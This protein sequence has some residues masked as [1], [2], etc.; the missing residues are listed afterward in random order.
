MPL[1]VNKPSNSGKKLPISPNIKIPSTDLAFLSQILKQFLAA[2][3]KPTLNGMTKTPIDG[4]RVFRDPHGS[5]KQ[6]LLYQSGI[7]IMLQGTKRL[8]V[9]NREIE[10]K[11]GDYI[12]FGVPLPAQCAATLE[13]DDCI[14]GLVIDIPAALLVELSQWRD[15]SAKNSPAPTFTVSQ[16]SLD[17]NIT[18]ATRRLLTALNNGNS[19]KAL[20]AGFVREIVYYILNGP[21]GHVLCGLTD[22]GHY[23]R[24]AQALR[25]IHDE[26]ASV[27]NVDSL[28]ASVNMSVSGFHRA[29]RDVVLDSPVQYIK[30]FRLSKARELIALGYRVGDAAEEVGYKSLSQFSRE[31]K[32]YYQFTPVQDR[33]SVN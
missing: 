25:T 15:D 7:I 10:Y 22:N 19:A 3:G 12:V 13:D 31:F 6:P 14:L 20:G 17:S 27:L 21:A 9:D 8:F 30:K 1:F 32:R 24:V 5:P 28:A 16:Q 26:Y 29:F 4:V 23:A 2:K 11:K 33:Q 18:D